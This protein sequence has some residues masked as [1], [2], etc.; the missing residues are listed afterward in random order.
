MRRRR[1]TWCVSVGA[2][3]RHRCSTWVVSGA[4]QSSAG[5]RRRNLPCAVCRDRRSVCS[6][7][8]RARRIGWWIGGVRSVLEESY[9]AWRRRPRGAAVVGHRSSKY[10]GQARCPTSLDK[11]WLGGDAREKNNAILKTHCVWSTCATP[12]RRHRNQ[13]PA[14]SS[15]LSISLAIFFHGTRLQMRSDA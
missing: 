2:L 11:L 15:S 8:D 7:T 10:D 3:T 13:P 1:G 14:T 5:D 6:R 12:E 9:I 4:Q